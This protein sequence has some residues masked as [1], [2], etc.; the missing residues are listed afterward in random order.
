MDL[1]VFSISL[2]VRDLTASRAFYEKLGFEVTGGAEDHHY[3][4]MVSGDAVIGL[5]Q[6]MFERNILTFNPGGTAPTWRVT[7]ASRTSGRSPGPWRMP[8][9]RS[10]TRACPRAE[11]RVTSRSWTRMATRS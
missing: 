3:L 2:A 9:S 5:F 8:A 1:G 10:P 4:I 7:R 6:G 11:G